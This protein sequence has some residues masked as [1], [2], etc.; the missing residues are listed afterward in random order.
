MAG[1]LCGVSGAV[2]VLEH[3]TVRIAKVGARS[4]DRAAAAVFLEKHVHALR[5]QAVYRRLVFGRID[6]ESVVHPVRHIERTVD[7]RSGALDQ[8]HAHA[9]G[10]EEGD[11]FI[12]P[13]RQKL[14]TDDIGVKLHTAFDI[15]HRNTKMG[16]PFDFRHEPPL[17]RSPSARRNGVFSR[18]LI[19]MLL[20][21]QVGRTMAAGGAAV[22]LPR[23]RILKLAVGAAALPSFSRFARAQS[24][25]QRPVRIIVGYPAGIAPDIV[26]RLMGDRLSQRLGQQFIVENRPGAGT[27]IAADDVVRAAADGYTLLLVA[28]ANTINTSLYPDL[29]FNFVRDIAAVANLGGVIFLMAVNPSVP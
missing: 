25:P 3:H 4:V 9:A 17:F 16:D 26:A 18:A 8:Q 14:A 21:I 10:I 27:S 28:A 1:L 20:S 23:R 19:A 22:Q 13:L 29:N 15:A 6:H 2:D 7:D 24:W 12:G 11:A 5:A